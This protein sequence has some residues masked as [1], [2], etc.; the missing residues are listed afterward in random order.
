VILEDAVVDLMIAILVTKIQR[1][2]RPISTRR[3]IDSICTELIFAAVPS[4]VAACPL[5][6][7]NVQLAIEDFVR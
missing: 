7:S 4:G 5:T 1:R 6:H 2:K 3:S